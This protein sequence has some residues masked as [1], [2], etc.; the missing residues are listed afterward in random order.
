MAAKK[1]AKKKEFITEPK[2]LAAYKK[3]IEGEPGVE[4]KG[5][6]HPYTSLNGNMYSMISKANEIGIRL[7][8]EDREAFM[9][10]YDTTLFEGVPGYFMKDYVAIPANLHG[11]TRALRSWFRK[12]FAHASSLKPKPTT[13]KKK[14]KK[15][16]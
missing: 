11:N 10:K 4:W 13:K 9:E 8:K 1:A 12:S 16:K 14:T 6:T 7:G 3:M 5:A 2:V 15:K